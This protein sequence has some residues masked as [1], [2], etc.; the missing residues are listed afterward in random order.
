MKMN[1]DDY[2]AYAFG[3]NKVGTWDER[4]MPTGWHIDFA[5]LDD[6][7]PRWLCNEPV[8]RLADGPQCCVYLRGLYSA[9]LTRARKAALIRAGGAHALNAA[10]GGVCGGAGPNVE[11]SGVPAGHLSNHPAG[12]TSAGTQG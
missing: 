3:I 7:L 1:A 12:G 6:E 2:G 8:L 4:G 10:G 9:E 11:F 5:R